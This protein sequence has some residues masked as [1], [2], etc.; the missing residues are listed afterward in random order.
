MASYE[1]KDVIRS[2]VD[3]GDFYEIHEHY[4][5]NIL[6]GFARLDGRTIGRERELVW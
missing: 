5:K 1:M 2:I 4:A 3:N 6:V